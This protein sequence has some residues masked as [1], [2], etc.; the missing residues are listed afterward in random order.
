MTRQERT[1]R[2]YP[3]TP[4]WVI[5]PGATLDEWFEYT[6]LPK[7]V[8]TKLYGLTDEELAGVLDGSWEITP[9]LAQKLLNLTAIP[10]PFWLALEQNFRAGLAAGLEWLR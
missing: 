8:A 1:T 10:V 6:H 4:N 5:H 3:F 9:E 7:T 2:T